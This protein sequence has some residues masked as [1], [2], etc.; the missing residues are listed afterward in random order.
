MFSLFLF[1]LKKNC[2]FFY[3]K[4]VNI[5]L[6]ISFPG[7]Y[8]PENNPPQGEILIGG[9]SVSIG[10]WKQPEKTAESFVVIDGVRY[11]RTGDIGQMRD[12]G[13]LMIIGYFH[14]FSQNFKR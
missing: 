3:V 12:D 11:F 14:S 8:S 6:S 10:Y 7:G 5:E 9:N 1:S 13:S 2:T 4:T